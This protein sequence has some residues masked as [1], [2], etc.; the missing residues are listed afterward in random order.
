MPPRMTAGRRRASLG[1][2][3]AESR[4]AT[5]QRHGELTADGRWMDADKKWRRIPLPAQLERSA[6][7]SKTSR[8]AW[9]VRRRRELATCCGWSRTTQPRSVPT[10][11]LTS[12]EDAVQCP[13]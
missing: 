5:A 7:V 9:E 1:H 13:S 10:P 12:E 6:A 3:G 2:G 4:N 11:Q 8:S